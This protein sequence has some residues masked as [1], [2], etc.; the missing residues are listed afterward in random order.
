MPHSLPH[1]SK[2]VLCPGLCFAPMLR[3]RFAAPDKCFASLRPSQG[4]LAQRARVQS[5]GR[6]QGAFD[7]KAK[8]PRLEAH[9][10]EVDV[11]CAWLPWAPF[12]NMF[13]GKVQA[14]S[15]SDQQGIVTS[16]CTVHVRNCE[17]F[18][19]HVPCRRRMDWSKN[20]TLPSQ[21][22]W[23]GCTPFCWQA[24]GCT[25]EQPQQQRSTSC[26]CM[27]LLGVR[28]LSISGRL[29]AASKPSTRGG[30]RIVLRA[31]RVRFRDSIAESLQGE[32]PRM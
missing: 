17:M 32:I 29:G 10:F 5:P 15:T 24:Q 21:G 26:L 6:S 31:A 2:W 23:P 30:R 25:R 4:S 28:L 11:V 12:M 7:A 27:R 18:V 9:S 3:I 20:D 19:V 22:P 8:K 1:C 13:R 14:D 16:Y